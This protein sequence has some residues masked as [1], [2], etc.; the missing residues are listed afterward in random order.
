MKPNDYICLQCRCFP[1]YCRTLSVVRPRADRRQNDHLINFM[2]RDLTGEVAVTPS[3]TGTLEY[4]SLGMNAGRC[5][6]TCHGSDHNPKDYPARRKRSTGAD[7]T[8][9]A[10]VNPGQMLDFFS[11]YQY[12]PCAAV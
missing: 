5:F 10:A 11:L 2:S 9:A 3:S 4:V 8:T 1:L 6:L 7:A 12:G